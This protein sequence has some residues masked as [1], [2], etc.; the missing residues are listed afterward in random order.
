MVAGMLMV[1][2]FPLLSVRQVREP[3]DNADHRCPGKE[4]AWSGWRSMSHSHNA[5]P[6]EA[7]VTAAW[8]QSRPFTGD[9]FDRIT[10]RFWP[11]QLSRGVISTRLRASEG[12]NVYVVAKPDN[13]K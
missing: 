7:T 2:G 1:I 3:F 5:Q 13:R 6:G 8:H 12:K 4:S 11:P 9:P 10:H